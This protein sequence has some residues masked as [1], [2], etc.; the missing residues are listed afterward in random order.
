MTYKCL[1]SCRLELNEAV[2]NGG[3]TYYCVSYSRYDKSEVCYVQD[4]IKR[5]CEELAT[6][7]ME[8]DATVYVCG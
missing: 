3:L 6:L 8:R 4:N 1:C 2:K 7:I 5:Y